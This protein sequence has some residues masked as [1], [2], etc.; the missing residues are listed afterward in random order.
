MF[1]AAQAAQKRSIA[2]LDFISK[3]T[4]AQA[5]QK[6]RPI[7]Y[8]AIN[9]FTAAQAA[10]KKSLITSNIT[11]YVHCRTGSLESHIDRFQFA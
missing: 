4:A 1:T 11:F 6:D 7:N 3:F 8:D 9:E 2:D 5:A 10:Q